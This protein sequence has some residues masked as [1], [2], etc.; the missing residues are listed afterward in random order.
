[1]DTMLCGAPSTRLQ[2]DLEGGE[3]VWAFVN[4]LRVQY[5][6]INHGQGFPNWSSPEFVKKAI[7]N[8][9][10]NDCNQYA[11]NTGLS[12]LKQV[13][14]QRYTQKYENKYSITPQ[15][16]QITNGCAG[17]LD[18][19][20]RAFLNPG[21][22]VIVIEPFFTF[23]RTQV[24]QSQGKIVT[25][26]LDLERDSNG[27]LQFKF[28]PQKLHDVINDKTRIFVLNTPHNPTGYVISLQEMQQ[29]A[30]IMRKYPKILVVTDEVYDRI[31]SEPV[32]YFASIAPDMF[33]RTIVCGSA[34]KTYSITGWKI[35]WCVGPKQLIEYVNYA[36]R[37]HS[38]CVNAPCQQGVADALVEACAPYKGCANYYVWLNDMYSRKRSL[39]L[40]AIKA[41]GM[42]AIEPKGA[43]Y[44]MV[45][46]SRYIGILRRRGVFKTVD[47]KD[48]TT[49]YDWQFVRWLMQEIG[50]AVVPGSAFYD[51]NKFNEDSEFGFIRFACCTSDETIQKTAERLKLLPKIFNRYQSKL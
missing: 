30:D 3:D 4:R 7:Q 13:L 29:I 43:Y 5:N 38:W 10:Q 46:A 49:F 1:M 40:N 23:Y 47:L 16:I 21:D 24:C 31:S 51:Y 14:A 34:A 6:A 12:S 28:N 8:A 33:N 9:V 45:D 48:P 32:H 27:T 20:F 37:G 22:E 19:T 36:C 26:S 25:I 15:H 50:V 39:M 17:A 44:I 11:P 35:G 42:E 41:S 2:F 18:S